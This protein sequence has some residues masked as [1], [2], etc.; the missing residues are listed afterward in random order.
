M[1]YVRLSTW[2]SRY[3][4]IRQSP[5]PGMS[6]RQWKA[7]RRWIGRRKVS[8]AAKKAWLK[9]AKLMH[10]LAAVVSPAVHNWRV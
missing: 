3:T 10:R 5:V 7:C 4:Y 2:S 1:P 9:D 6:F 8:P